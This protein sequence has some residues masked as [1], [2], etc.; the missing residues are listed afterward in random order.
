MCV[1]WM[2]CKKFMMLIKVMLYG[3][4][5]LRSF[6]CIAF[7]YVAIATLCTRSFVKSVNNPDEKLAFSDKPTTNITANTLTATILPYH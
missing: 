5:T 6:S 4:A 2:M 1:N 3:V 7:R